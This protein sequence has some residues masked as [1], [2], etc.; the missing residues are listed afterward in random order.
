VRTSLA[1]EYDWYFRACFAPVSRTVFLIVHDRALA[2]DI[3]Q[4]ALYRM[5]RHWHTVSRYEAPE[6]WVRR[7]A[8][9]IAVREVQR[10]VARPGK[11]RLGHTVLPEPDLPD[12]DLARAVASLAPMQRA[13]VVL[14]YWEDRPI[15]E[16]ARVLSVSESTVKQHLYRA[17]HR[18]AELLGEEVRG[19]AG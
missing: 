18:L 4:E 12:P 8:I 11:E 7:V 16:I 19:D 10:A 1:Q 6:A 2:E 3:T 13:A 14:Y 9:R 5:L 17:R 15:K